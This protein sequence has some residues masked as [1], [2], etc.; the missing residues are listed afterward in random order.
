MLYQNYLKEFWSTAIAYDPSPSIEE[1][2]QCPLREFFIKFSVLNGKRPL[3]LDFNTFCSSTGLDY[4]NGKYVAHLTPEVLGGNYSSNEQVNSIQQL[5]AYSLITGTED[6]KF[7]FLPSILS[8][9]NFTKGPSKVSNIELMAHMITVN[10][11]KDLVSSLLFSG[12]K[13]KVKSQTVTPILPKSQGPEA[14]ESLPQKRIKPLSKKAPKETKA[15]P[16]LS[17]CRVLSNPTQ[18]S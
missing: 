8:N 6:V 18:S 9:S 12:K 5:L 4:K 14:L 15:T 13:N 1:T 3:T 11:Q 17:Q 16:P 10:N 7:E 2:E